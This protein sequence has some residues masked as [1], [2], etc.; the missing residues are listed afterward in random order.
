MAFQKAATLGDL[1]GGEMLAVTLDGKRVLLVNR[2]GIVSAFEDRCAHQGVP[3]SRGRFDGDRL[4]CSVHEW[5]Y[6]AC[7]GRG[8]NPCGVSLRSF[9]VA[10]EGESI[11][12]DLAGMTEKRSPID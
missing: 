1:W 3:L 11:L 10:I 12:V 9:P 5:T 8:L 7:S 6:D 2:N 4:I